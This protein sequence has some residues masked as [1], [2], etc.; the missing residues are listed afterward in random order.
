M[1]KINFGGTI[2]EVVT[3]EVFQMEKALEVMKN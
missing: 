1:A 2:E 3:R